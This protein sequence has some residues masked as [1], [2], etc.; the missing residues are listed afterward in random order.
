MAGQPGYFYGRHVYFEQ[1]ADVQFVFAELVVSVQ[2]TAEIV[3]D[4][5]HGF[6]QC[7][8]FFAGYG[9]VVGQNL[10]FEQPV[11]VRFLYDGVQHPLFVFLYFGFFVGIEGYLLLHLQLLSQY[12]VFFAE[13]LQ[14][15]FQKCYLL[16]VLFDEEGALLVL[17]FFKAS[18]I[19]QLGIQQ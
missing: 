10:L 7:F 13:G 15:L 5:V 3:I 18:D 17:F 6:F 9:A 4:T 8:P 2:F 11:D 1:Q 12:F 16:F 19:F 14:L